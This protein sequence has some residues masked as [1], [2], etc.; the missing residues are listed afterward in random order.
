VVRSPL[1]A[2]CLRPVSPVSRRR[3]RDF[4]SSVV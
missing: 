1:C 2:Q 3:R 4:I